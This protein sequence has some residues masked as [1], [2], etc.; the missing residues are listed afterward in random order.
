M[1]RNYFPAVEKGLRE[2]IIK[3][4][5]AG[6]PVVYLKATLVFGSYHDVDSSEMAFKIAASLAYKAG[7]P[8]ADPVILEPIGSLKVFIPDSYMGDVIGDLQKR[9][10]RVMGMNPAE[11]GLQIIEAEVPMAEMH[12]YTIDLR[13]MTQGRGSFEFKFERYEDVP[14][15]IQQK[16]IE[17]RKQFLSEEE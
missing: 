5:L 14:M 16:I 17:E 7:L 8:Q 11:D 3:G 15:N 2:C 6:Y 4:V 9:R 13:S 12:T 10:G 1:P